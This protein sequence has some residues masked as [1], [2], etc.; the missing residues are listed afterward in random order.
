[1]TAARIRARAALA[2]LAC[3]GL[4]TCAGL[5]AA[6]VAP[7]RAAVPSAMIWKPIGHS[8]LGR[9]IV[10]ARFG[11]GR[12]H[13]L[14]VGGVHGDEYGSPVAEQFARWLTRHPS[15][16][17][18]NVTLDVIACANP[19]GRK[20]KKRW[21]ARLVDLNRNFPSA[22]WSRIRGTYGTAGHSPASEPETRV[23]LDRL[24]RGR[25]WRVVSL[26][27]RGPLI[28]YDGPNALRLA[29][30]MAKAAHTTAG[31][32]SYQASIHGSMGRYVPEKYKV[33]LITWELASP[34]MDG[35]VAAGLC[36]AL[37]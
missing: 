20:A 21:N 35:R 8:Q 2:A 27:S 32:I 34:T 26:H 14:I 15:A 7:A 29:Q 24:A 1:M 31:K 25:Y 33:P 22:D 19:D 18:R 4:L 6:P 30:R 9:D 10:M 16:V 13:V 12:R 28:D 3:A 17:P 23:L 11:D 37:R 5:A 36:A